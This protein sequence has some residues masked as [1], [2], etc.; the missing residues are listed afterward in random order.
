MRIL[1]LG[2]VLGAVSGG[3][4]YHGTGHGQ[5]STIVFILVAVATWL[6]VASIV[7]ARDTSHGR[8]DAGDWLPW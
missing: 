3:L 2:L 1:L 5:L 8:A 4:T 7:I 6:G